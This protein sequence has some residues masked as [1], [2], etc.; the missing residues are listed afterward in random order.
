LLGREAIAPHIALLER[1]AGEL[2]QA[3]LVRDAECG[4]DEE[5]V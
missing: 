3:G 4:I 2:H 5:P 1:T